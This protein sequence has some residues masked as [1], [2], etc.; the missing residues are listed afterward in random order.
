MITRIAIDECIGPQAGDVLQ[1][2][3]GLGDG[4]PVRVSHVRR[5]LKFGARSDDVWID[6]LKPASAW[7]IITCD[8]GRGKVGPPLPLEAA[9]RNVPVLWLFG[10][11]GSRTMIEQVRV[12]LMMWPDVRRLVLPLANGRRWRIRCM[13]NSGYRLEEWPERQTQR[14]LPFMAAAASVADKAMARGE[15]GA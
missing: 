11:L 3:L 5:D 2:F 14:Q 10:K 15:T 4:P 9:K 8:F 1:A 13:A 7:L 12:L 6:V